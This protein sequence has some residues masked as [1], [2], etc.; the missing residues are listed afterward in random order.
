MVLCADLIMFTSLRWNK[1]V[2]THVS[3]CQP[4]FVFKLHPPLNVKTSAKVKILTGWKMQVYYQ[5]LPLLFKA[6]TIVIIISNY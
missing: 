1:L 3:I 2:I 6:I 5:T 4:Y